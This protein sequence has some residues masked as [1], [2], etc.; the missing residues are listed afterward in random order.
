M[1][2][3]KTLGEG[4]EVLFINHREHQ[5]LWKGGGEKAHPPEIKLDYNQE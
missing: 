5:F 3:D 4:G 2:S 1:S